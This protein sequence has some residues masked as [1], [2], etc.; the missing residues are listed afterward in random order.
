MVAFT[1]YEY[2][3]MSVGVPDST[4]VEAPMVTVPGRSLFTREYVM[5]PPEAAKVYE[6]AEPVGVTCGG[7]CAVNVGWPTTGSEVAN[8]VA[9]VE[10]VPLLAVSV[11]TNL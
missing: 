4:P 6:N 3:A 8:E 5:L 7:D 11:Y 1:A 2:E 10:A 9:L